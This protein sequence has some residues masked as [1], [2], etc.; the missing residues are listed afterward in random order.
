MKAPP[1]KPP[2]PGD[3]VGGYRV[4]EKLGDGGFGFVYKVERAGRYYA[5]KVIRAR[6]LESWGQREINILRHVVHPNVVR[7]RACDRWPDPDHGYLCFV[8]DLVV[9]RTLDEWAL[10]ENPTARQV[11]RVL[12]EVARAL[13]NIL[14]Q[15]VLHRDLKREN[16]LIRDEDGRPVLV[17][18]GIGWLAGEPTIT[19]EREP[20]GTDEYRSPEHILFERDPS[21]KKVGYRPDV[22]D[23]LWALG[24]TFYWLLTD[25]L[26]FGNRTEGGLEDRILAQRPPSPHAYSS[27]VPPVLSA[28]CMRMLEKRR[29]AR[30]ANYEELCGALEAALSAADGDAAWDVPLMDPDAP[31]AT[32]TVKVPGMGPPAGEEAGLAWKAAR[33]RRG[34]GDARKRR[35]AQESGGTPA[36]PA[37]AP[38]KLAQPPAPAKAEAAASPAEALVAVLAEVALE[39]A[40][41]SLPPP[42]PESALLSPPL[43]AP[44]AVQPAAVS[45]RAA[46]PLPREPPPP[47]RV[48]RSP[49]Q[50]TLSRF[51][52]SVVGMFPL[53][54]MAVDS[55]RHAALFFVALGALAV[56]SASAWVVRSRPAPD[57]APPVQAVQHAP[58]PAES[59]GSGPTTR[60]GAV[61]EVANSPESSEAGP[62]AALSL[63]STP[64]LATAMPLRKQEP[65][66][67][68]QEMPA[69]APQPRG[70]RCKKWQCLAASCGWVLVACT[71]GPQVRSTPKVEACSPEALASMK[72]LDI[73]IGDTAG[74]TFPVVGDAKPVTV[75]EFTTFELEEH[76]GKLRPGTVLSGRLI[77]GESRVY[78]RFTQA[79]Q[80]QSKGG[81]TY[82]VCLELQYRGQRGTAIMRDGGPDSA[83]VGSTA[84][85]E[86]VE[87]FE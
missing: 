33:P 19:G 82:P 41:E 1:F 38:V 42:V 49:F 83:V 63:A 24:V 74:G 65:R 52:P 16:I 39:R 4:M 44:A 54:A 75:Q 62:G 20:P 77:F 40:W 8:M 43:P 36:V 85:V 17:D 32:P 71:G 51:I 87:R 66:L 25:V 55:L 7:F 5:L 35:Q 30:F 22:G 56:A 15:G 3:M 79:K 86:A 72:E 28:L 11:V 14:A 60:A 37:P 53:R 9:G 68:P 13:A 78:G 21:K 59:P 2:E 18:F 45:V 84:W 27:R 73:D 12:L 10:D 31:D 48:V 57:A 46:P 34:R 23:E 47:A 6:E 50:R 58:L 81:Q 64:A 70:G 61:R 69:P 80:T 76:L 29:E 26:P 67:P